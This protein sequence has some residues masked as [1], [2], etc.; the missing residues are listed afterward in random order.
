VRR[1]NAEKGYGRITAEA[2]DGRGIDGPGAADSAE[3]ETAFPD[4][5]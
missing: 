4:E 5:R 3:S 2:A 1:C